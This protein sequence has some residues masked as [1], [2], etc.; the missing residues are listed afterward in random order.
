MAGV[1]GIEPPNAWTKTMCLTT[2]RHPK[3][4]NYSSTKR[5]EMLAAKRFFEVFDWRIP[6]LVEDE[7]LNLFVD[8]K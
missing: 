5:V 8:T 7:T 2:W 3:T 6:A 4:P 1:E